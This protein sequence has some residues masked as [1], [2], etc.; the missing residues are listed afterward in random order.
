MEQFDSDPVLDP[1]QVGFILLITL[2]VSFLAAPMIT[3]FHNGAAL[4]L[5]ELF[6][7]LPAAVYINKLD[8]P[9]WTTFRLRPVNIKLIGAT[10]VFFL[11][12]F[13]FIDELD[14][15]VQH[16]FPMPKDWLDSLTDLVRFDGFFESSIIILAAVLVAPVVEEM[17]FRALV[18]RSLEKY[19]EPAIAIVLASVLF[20]LVH[21]NPWTSIQITLLGLVLGYMTWKSGS[22]IPAVVLH[23]LNNLFSLLL[24]N[25]DESKLTWY[26]RNGHVNFLWIVL[27]ALFIFPAFQFF[28][29]I[30]EKQK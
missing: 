8:V 16:V 28:N 24:M 21:F 5:G 1:R 30:N 25:V 12:I 13:I 4:L 6:L 9:F 20:A 18:Q 10:L 22:I 17:L 2:L 7:I 19:L 14:R 15:L 26:A 27:A 23:G 29:R 11:P 3:L